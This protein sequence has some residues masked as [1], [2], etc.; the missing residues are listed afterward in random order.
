MGRRN[1]ENG[2]ALPCIG[3]GV[4][5]D[6][7]SVSKAFFKFMLILSTEK[8]YPKIITQIQKYSSCKP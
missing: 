7:F 2:R 5:V 6:F 4:I 1:G 8:T 3:I